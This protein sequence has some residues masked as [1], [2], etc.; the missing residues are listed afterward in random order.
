MA[1]RSLAQIGR[2]A[3]ARHSHVAESHHFGDGDHTHLCQM[4]HQ[5]PSFRESHFTYAFRDSSNLLYINTLHV[6]LRSVPPPDPNG[7]PLA[8]V[9]VSEWR[10]IWPLNR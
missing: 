9:E 10:Q 7:V 6:L 8:L 3:C 1:N 5:T 4:T 2:N